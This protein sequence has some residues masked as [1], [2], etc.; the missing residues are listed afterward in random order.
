MLVT[1]VGQLAF[2]AAAAALV[3]RMTAGV[4]RWWSLALLAAISGYYGGIGTFRFAE[5]FATARTFAEPL[6]LAALASMLSGRLWWALLVLAFAA[7]VHPLVAAPGIG[8]VFLW[9]TAQRPRLFWLAPALLA[10]VVAIAAAGPGLTG[11]FDPAWRADVLE[12][13]P[14]LFISQWLAPDWARLI[15]GLCSIWL[16]LRW[17]ETRVR[18][19]VLAAVVTALVGIAGTWLGVDVLDSVLA[20]GLQ[21]WRAHWLMQVLAIMLLPVSVAGL[22][23]LGGA[24][25]AAAAMLAAS[26]CFGRAE[27][28]AGAL[29][30]AVAVALAWSERRWPGWMAGNLLRLAVTAALAAASVGALLEVQARLP[31]AYGAVHPASWTDY[32]SAAGSA[33]I[34]ALLAFLFWLAACSRFPVRAAML[35]GAAL[36]GS[37]VVWDGRSSW[38]RFIERAGDRENPF[39][40]VLAPGEQ[41]FWPGPNGPVWIALRTATWF[42]VDQG[43]GIAFNRATAMEYSAR[44]LASESLRA[45]IQ[46]CAIAY[47]AACGIDGEVAAALC[48]WR[49]T[50]PHYLVLNGRIEGRN[51][52]ATWRTPAVNGPGHPI[53]HLYSCRDLVGGI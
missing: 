29:L 53:L 11:R 35:A 48:R 32:L 20:A 22:W 33:G 27:L 8:V 18:H 28:S 10:L 13:S 46:N 9:R 40:A 6:V 15:W 26:C 36:A 50:G 42:S 25:R 24:S 43:A 1:I 30:A 7:I 14:H 17:V 52:S 2:L 44:K 12:R 37:I 19:M 51:P 23:R 45:R 47:P 21:L 38:S 3:A 5:P 49:W 16:A 31:R 34:L 41:V 39:R 4:E